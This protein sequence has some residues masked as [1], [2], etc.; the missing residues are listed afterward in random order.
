MAFSPT[1]PVSAYS[2]W[3]QS[4]STRRRHHRPR[5]RSDWT[6]VWVLLLSFAALALVYGMMPANE[7]VERAKQAVQKDTVQEESPVVGALG[8]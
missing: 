6:V 4:R 5:W 2:L 8:P 3:L 7:A 1:D